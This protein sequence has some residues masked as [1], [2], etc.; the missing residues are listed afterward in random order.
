MRHSAVNRMRGF[1]ALA[2]LHQETRK[3][4]A[5]I[6]ETFEVLDEEDRS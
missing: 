5:C 3:V 4:E 2:D 1:G 6:S